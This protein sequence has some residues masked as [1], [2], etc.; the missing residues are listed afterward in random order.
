VAIL[1]HDPP[2]VSTR[3]AVA[4]PLVDRIV[5]KCLTKNP[6]GRW[7]SASD[8]ASELRWVADEKPHGASTAAGTVGHREGVRRWL[9]A[10]TAL[11]AVAGAL[12]LWALVARG[13]VSAPSPPA[14]RFIPVTFRAGSVNSARFAPDGETVVYTASWQGQPY[15]L[16]MTRRGSPESRSLNVEASTCSAAIPMRLSTSTRQASPDGMR[17]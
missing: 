1:T 5:S 15:T 13:V 8:V 11:G 14:P 7:Q 17:C 10:A 12:G 4:S 2:G 3:C 6:D 16:Y 9:A